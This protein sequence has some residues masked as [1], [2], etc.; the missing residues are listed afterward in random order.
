[1]STFRRRIAAPQEAETRAQRALDRAAAMLKAYAADGMTMIS[2]EEVQELLG[3]DPDYA[4]P[5]RP[6][7]PRDPRADPLT[8]ALW[9]GPPGSA[10]PG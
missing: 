1:M 5:V 7:P 3:Q 2:I 10:P 6:V 4:P 9:A 8:G